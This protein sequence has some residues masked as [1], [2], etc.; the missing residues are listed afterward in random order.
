MIANAV[1]ALTEIS[2]VSKDR[3]I[4]Q[5][6]QVILTKLLAALNECTEYDLNFKYKTH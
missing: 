4:F 1:A 5:L 3:D 2:Q 6:N